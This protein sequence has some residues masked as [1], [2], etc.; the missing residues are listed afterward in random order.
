MRRELVSAQFDRRNEA[1]RD[2]AVLRVR[3][4]RIDRRLPLALRNL[5]G[6]A[7]VRN[8]PGVAFSKRDEDQDAAPVFGARDAAA[9]ELL[10]AARCAAARRAARGMSATRM[11]GTQSNPAS[12]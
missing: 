1:V 7:V 10:H 5:G 8:D 3:N 6:N 12:A 11:R 9:D 4:E 2:A